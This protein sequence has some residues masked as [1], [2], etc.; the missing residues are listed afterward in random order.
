MAK[1]AAVE[2]TEEV[3]SPEAQMMSLFKANK[4]DHYNFEETQ[5]YKVPAS[6]LVLTSIMSGGLAPGAHRF[7]GA[8]SGGKSS[9]ALD[10]MFNFFK[11]PRK[12]RGFYFK[13]EGR[14]NPEIRARSGLTFVEKIEDWRDGTCLIVDS[15]VFEFVFDVMRDAIVTNP[16]KCQY[17][18]IV[19][20]VDMMV[21]RADLAKTFEESQQVAGGALIT[22]VFLKKVQ[23][24]MSKRGHIAVFISQV[25]ET[26][27]INPYDKTPPKQGN[28][29]G[30]HALEHAGDFVLEF[31]N[32]FGDDIIRKDDE[33]NGKPLGHFAKCK[34][35]KSGNE[36]YLQEARYPICY[37][38]TGGNSVW[39]E[40]EVYDMMVMWELVK[41]TGA[42]YNIDAGL[43]KEL[44]E[45]G[46]T[47]DE[48]F[49]GEARIDA[50]LNANPDAVNYLAEK[51]S[52][53]IS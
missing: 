20:S 27:K 21:R 52:K 15:N 24:A 23:N 4:D 25:R 51:F 19:D 43:I 39:R 17:F 38:R 6:S 45:Q 14:L 1:K 7:T 53:M 47:M 42:W 50:W 8:S 32:R 2:E 22:S 34:I 10:F 36:S 18:M 40:K 30:G 13:C 37:G 33:K 44:A 5:Y 49:N 31:L 11:S 12:R 41:R 16:S 35:V 29:S 26:V 28:A 3:V 9:Q 48:K 46:I